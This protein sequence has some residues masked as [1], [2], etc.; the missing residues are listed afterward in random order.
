MQRN[1]FMLVRSVSIFSTWPNVYYSSVDSVMFVR[2]TNILHKNLLVFCSL[3]KIQQRRSHIL[4]WTLLPIYLEVLLDLMPYL[5]LLTD[6]VDMY[7][8]YHAIAMFLHLM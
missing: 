3:L 4:P 8:L 6:L 7:I 1:C 2:L 5:P